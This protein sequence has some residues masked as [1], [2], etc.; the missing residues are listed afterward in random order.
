MAKKTKITKEQLKKL[1]AK[2]NEMEIECKKIGSKI[3]LH[4]R[5][6]EKK[7][8]KDFFLIIFKLN[9]TL[10]CIYLLFFFCWGSK[11]VRSF[12]ADFFSLYLSEHTKLYF[13][14][15]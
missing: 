14:M 2:H 1:S 6:L 11:I 13:I 9:N 15:T 5:P 7:Y 4:F 10:L 12:E 3:H 8:M